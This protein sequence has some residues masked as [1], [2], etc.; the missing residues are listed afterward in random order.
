MLRPSGT[1]L[2]AGIDPQSVASTPY[3]KPEYGFHVRAGDVLT[4]LHRDAGFQTIE[5]VPYDEVTVRPDG[6]P[7]ARRYSFVSAKP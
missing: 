4:A 3:A 7:W 6:T 5:M 2:I 1:S